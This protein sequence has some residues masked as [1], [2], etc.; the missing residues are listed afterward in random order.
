MRLV[1]GT[2][3]DAGMCGLLAGEQLERL[4]PGSEWLEA[5]PGIIESPWISFLH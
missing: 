1:R 4:D 2:W 3:R 5:C